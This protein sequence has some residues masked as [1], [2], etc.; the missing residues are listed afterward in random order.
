MNDLELIFGMLG[1]LQLL[2][3]PQQRRAVDENKMSPNEECCG[4]QSQKDWR[5]SGKKVSAKDGIAKQGK[6]K[7]L[8][9]NYG[10]Y[11]LMQIKMIKIFITSQL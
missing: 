3:R 9:T 2:N 4:R 10:N 7:R 5:K 8:Q 6:D 1:K 11:F